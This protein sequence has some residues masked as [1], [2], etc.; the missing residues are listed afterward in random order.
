M[1]AKNS[2]RSS[3]AVPCQNPRGIQCVHRLCFC[4]GLGIGRVGGELECVRR[5]PGDARQISASANIIGSPRVDLGPKKD[6][7]PGRNDE[8]PQHRALVGSLMRLSAI[9]RYD[10][11]NALSACARHSHNSSPRYWKAFLQI[12]TYVNA[13]TAVRSSDLKL[14]VYADA[15]Y[16]VVSNDRRSM[17]GFAVSLKDTAIGWKRS[18][19]KCV[20]TVT[21]EAEYVALCDG[22]KEALFMKSLGIPTA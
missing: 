14:S 9:T 15:G 20:T 12:T 13:T 19:W 2:S 18:A 22:S 21:Y 16:A 11:A 3:R 8:F 1:C 10:I 17:S 7:E 6:G 4:L 5:N